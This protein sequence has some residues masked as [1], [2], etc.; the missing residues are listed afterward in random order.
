MQRAWKIHSNH[1]DFGVLEKCDKSIMEQRE[2]HWISVFDSRKD[3]FGYN[4]QSASR[5]DSSNRFNKS[6]RDKMS[7]S[8]K[9]YFSENPEAKNRLVER[10]KEFQTKENAAKIARARSITRSFKNESTGEVFIG[11]IRDLIE[12]CPEN[13]PDKAALLRVSQGKNRVAKNWIKLCA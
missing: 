3:L 4:L 10:M 12:K 11:S 2:D 7:V 5:D 13:K 9:R 1:F 8:R 6:V